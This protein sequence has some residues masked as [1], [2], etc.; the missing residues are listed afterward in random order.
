MNIISLFSGC[1][2]LDLGFENAGFNVVF[3]NDIDESLNYTYEK[4][5]HILL[6]NR[7]ITDLKAEDLPDADGIIGGPPCQS[8]SLAGKMGG[9]KDKRGMLFF[10][11][12]RVI[13]EKKPK[14]FVAENVPGI[15]SKTHISEFKK[16]IGLLE[17]AGYAISYELLDARDYGV[18]QERRRVI[19]VGYRKDLHMAFEFPP[20]THSKESVMTIDGRFL[21]KYITLKEAIGDLPD[22]LPVQPKSKANENLP[23]PNHEYMVGPFSTIYMSRN[24]R[25]GWDGC[26]YTIQAGGRHAPLHPSSSPMC[27]I[28]KD[29][30]AF[31]EKDP[32]YRRLSVREAARIQTFPDNFIFYYK[33]VADGYKMVGNAVPVKLAEAI[34]R[35]IYLDLSKMPHSKAS[36]YYHSV[37]EKHE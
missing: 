20:P 37:A 36:V 32:K 31:L 19:I 6:D 23:F 25:K 15:M 10:E 26:S 7:S 21:S 24:R 5:H 33:N 18:P 2:G 22:A 30:W 4:N 17:A 34:A 14:F 9:S 8:W 28:S 27:K 35:K 12:V 13:K 29:E 11:Y 1:G 3:A 16:L